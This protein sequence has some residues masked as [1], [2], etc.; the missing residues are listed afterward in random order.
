MN[1]VRISLTPRFSGVF[2]RW[3]LRMNRFSGF[4]VPGPTNAIEKPLKRFT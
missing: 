3:W 2:V 4:S 1:A